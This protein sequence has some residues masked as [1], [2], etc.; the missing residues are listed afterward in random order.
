MTLSARGIDGQGM[1]VS[2]IGWGP[3][4]RWRG[5]VLATEGEGGVVED[6]AM[7]ERW[8]GDRGSRPTCGSVLAWAVNTGF[9]RVW[10]CGRPSSVSAAT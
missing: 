5:K 8:L 6:L 1:L 2:Q 4:P 9:C 3:A 10:G 7:S